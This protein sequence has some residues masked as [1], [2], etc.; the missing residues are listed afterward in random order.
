MGPDGEDA[1]YAFLRTRL[2]G[3]RSQLSRYKT[4]ADTG[5]YPGQADI[6]EGL[7]LIKALLACEESYTFIERFNAR[8]DELRDVSDSYHDLEHFYEHQKPTW[9]RL[10]KA[11]TTYMLNRSQLEQDATAAPA[12][13]RMQE[14]LAAQSPYGLIQEA[15][16]LITTVEGVNTALLAE[17]RTVIC[18]KIDNVMATLTQ[19]MDA[20]QGDDGTTS[21]CLGPLA[22]LRVQV[23]G[24]TSIAHIVQAEQQ[25][26]ALLGTAQGHIQAFVRKVAE[27]RGSTDT[28]SGPVP[29]Q[30]V[31]KKVRSYS[32]SDL[33]HDDLSGNA[34]GGRRV[35]H[36]AE[37]RTGPGTCPG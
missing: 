16:G 28:G 24:E 7:T 23:E 9:D 30:P 17:H 34:A 33:G 29:P 15:E 37:T 4:L 12:L 26:L 6:N 19:D 5:Q 35:P 22:K 2:E 14:V 3:W 25:A 1:L 18:Q 36:R 11:Y 21:V 10:S 13:R 20:A 8:K 32:T 31:V 27:Q